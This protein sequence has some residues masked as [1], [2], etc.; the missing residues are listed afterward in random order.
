MFPDT[1][2]FK[3]TIRLFNSA[4]DEKLP[5]I[6]QRV[7]K[8]IDGKAE[9]VFSEDEEDQLKTILNV[10][11]IHAFIEGCCFVFER[12]AFHNANASKLATDLTAQGLEE[13]KVS[14]FE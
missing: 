2:R 5:L 4:S 12:A 7:L 10:P 8:K 14:L 6:L 11:R 3:E 13:T 9:R 1:E